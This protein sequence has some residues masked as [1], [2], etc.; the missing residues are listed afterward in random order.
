MCFGALIDHF[1]G[2]SCHIGANERID[3]AAPHCTTSSCGTGCSGTRT[4]VDCTCV[5]G[6]GPAYTARKNAH[7]RTV[8]PNLQGKNLNP[9]NPLAV[10][11]VSGIPFRGNPGYRAVK[12][13]EGRN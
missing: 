10:P 11:P 9:M 2:L 12:A 5:L 7:Q 4:R 3:V 1:A 8:L 6:S 13:R